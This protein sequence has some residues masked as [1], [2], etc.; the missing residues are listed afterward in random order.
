MHTNILSTLTLANKRFKSLPDGRRVF[1]ADFPFAGYY[2]L[3]NTVIENRLFTITIW[4]N[5]LLFVSALAI[6]LIFAWLLFFRDLIEYLGSYT[7]SLFL[8]AFF[9]VAGITRWVLYRNELRNL[10][11]IDLLTETE[12]VYKRLRDNLRNH[13]KDSL[14]NY[15]IG[16]LLE[17]PNSNEKIVMLKYDEPFPNVLRCHLDGSIIWQAELP[18]KSNDVYTNVQW[19]DGYLHAFSRSCV[20]VLLD[21]NTGKIVSGK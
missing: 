10:Q 9:T 5:V 3:P 20:S 13:S 4:T 11:K 8:A 16:T 15:E 1:L 12:L 14:P 18:T 6:W 17:I 2:L 7:G 19:K 21:E